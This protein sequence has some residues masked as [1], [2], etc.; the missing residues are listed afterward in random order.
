MKLRRKRIKYK[1][2]IINLTKILPNP[3]QI[4]YQIKPR[5]TLKTLLNHR[6]IIFKEKA[7]QIKK[8]NSYR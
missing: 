5:K 1:S 6:Q 2:R 4:L 7:T 8:N 3:K